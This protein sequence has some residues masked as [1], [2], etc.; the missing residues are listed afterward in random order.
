MCT[1]YVPHENSENGMP[2]GAGIS[3]SSTPRKFLHSI[4]IPPNTLQILWKVLLECQIDML[5]H[6]GSLCYKH[7]HVNLDAILIK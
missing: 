4:S 5:V 1:H 2:I 6:V 3:F 7:W